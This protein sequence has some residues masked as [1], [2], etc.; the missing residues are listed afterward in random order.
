VWGFKKIKLI[1]FLKKI[2][3]NNKAGARL[4]LKA[5]LTFLYETGIKDLEFQM[6]VRIETKN[7]CQC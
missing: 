7:N 1:F 4:G 6:P 3:N 5:F 2:N